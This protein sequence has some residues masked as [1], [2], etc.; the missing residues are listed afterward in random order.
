LRSQ[1]RHLHPNWHFLETPYGGYYG[2]KSQIRAGASPDT[3]YGGLG[4]GDFVDGYGGPAPYGS[5]GTVSIVGGANINYGLGNVGFGTG[6][7]VGYGGS[8]SIGGRQIGFGNLGYGG[9]FGGGMGGYGGRI[10]SSYRP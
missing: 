5:P 10:D 6:V 7:G 4:G 1:S 3:Q 2:D 9:G 8:G